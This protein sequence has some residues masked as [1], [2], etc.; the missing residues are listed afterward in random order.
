LLEIDFATYFAKLYLGCCYVKEKVMN[1]ID[2][3]FSN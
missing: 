3:C 1:R 2:W